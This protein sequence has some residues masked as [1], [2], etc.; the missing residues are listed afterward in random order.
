MNLMK[1]KLAFDCL[2]GQKWEGSKLRAKK[3][4]I[5]QH[6]INETEALKGCIFSP[7]MK[8]NI[9]ASSERNKI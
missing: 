6:F 8:Q 4:T 2:S 9:P 3:N 1:L 5:R 7:G